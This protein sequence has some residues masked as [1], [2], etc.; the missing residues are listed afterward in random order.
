MSANYIKLLGPTKYIRELKKINEEVD[1]TIP[2]SA[3]RKVSLPEENRIAA[4]IPPGDDV[5]YRWAFPFTKNSKSDSNKTVKDLKQDDPV[6][7]FFLYRML[8][9]ITGRIFD[10]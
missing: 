1:I 8:T 5:Y 10:L 3:A 4:K 7:A 2:V 6:I 9:D